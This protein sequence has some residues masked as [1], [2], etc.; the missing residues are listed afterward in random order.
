MSLF[1]EPR[2]MSAIGHNREDVG[3]DLCEVVHK[4]LVAN[5]ES[6]DLINE[7]NH[8]LKTNFH[9]LRFFMFHSENDC[10]HDCLEHLGVQLNQRGGA[11]FDDIVN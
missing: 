5:V 1:F 10:L 11:V 8:A 7:V 4:E 9:N 6:G 2:K 3:D